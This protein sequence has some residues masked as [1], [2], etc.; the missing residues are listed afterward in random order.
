MAEMAPQWGKE[1]GREGLG[2]QGAADCNGA[3]G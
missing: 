1:G 2:A 3:A